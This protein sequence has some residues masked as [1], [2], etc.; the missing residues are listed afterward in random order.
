MH[1]GIR[2]DMEELR[3]RWPQLDLGSGLQAKM[4]KQIE[5]A[6]AAYCNRPDN[7]DGRGIRSGTVAEVRTALRHLK[8]AARRATV[9]RTPE[10]QTARK[11]LKGLHHMRH[12]EAIS[13]GARSYAGLLQRLGKRRARRAAVCEARSIR[14]GVIDT[15][16]EVYLERL[17]SVAD[18]QDIG[19]RLQLCVADNDE[20]GREYQDRLRKKESEFW[21]LRTEVPLALLEVIRGGETG[22]GKIVE[23]QTTTSECEVKLSRSMLFRLARKL[24]ASGDEVLEFHDAGAFWALLHRPPPTATIEIGSARYRVW[25]F[26]DEVIIQGK[27][28]DSRGRRIGWSRF[29]R[30]AVRPWP[31]R[32]RG[33]ARLL[34][35][36]TVAAEDASQRITD[37]WTWTPTGY[38]ARALCDQ[39]LQSLVLKS[40]EMYE[41]LRN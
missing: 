40:V 35:R 31:S 26:R 24:D 37:S 34:R 5:R 6:I 16:G 10:G 30:E 25:R 20:I 2:N 13:E 1:T 22:H 27:A 28:E 14:L 29:V 15:L 33:R 9:V 38:G 11:L 12:F 21:K 4:P 39:Q 3:A 32:A 8:S 19:R 7:R 23:C 36:E 41:L 17:V 18:L